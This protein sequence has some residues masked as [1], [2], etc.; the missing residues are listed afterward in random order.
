MT[1]NLEF[2]AG[3]S[4]EIP[5]I[6]ID[7]PINTKESENTVMDHMIQSLPADNDRYYTKH[8]ESSNTFS[9][10]EDMLQEEKDKLFQ[11]DLNGDK[12]LPRLKNKAEQTKL[13]RIKSQ[14]S[15]C[16]KA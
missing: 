6:N 1:T 8:E 7:F 11:L 4:K 3:I 16:W 2:A 13:K 5:S 12:K 9:I 10:R 14:A 15:R